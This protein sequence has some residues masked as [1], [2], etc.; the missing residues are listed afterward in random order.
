MTARLIMAF[1]R[2]VASSASPIFSPPRYRPANHLFRRLDDGSVR[3]IRASS[4]SPN[5]C[6]PGRPRQHAHHALAAFVGKFSAA[7]SWPNVSCSAP[8]RSPRRCFV[9]DSC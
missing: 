3:A 9:V 4:T 8:T 1:L 7:G 6:R 5:R 2:A